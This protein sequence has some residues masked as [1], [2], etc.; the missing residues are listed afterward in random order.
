[1]RILFPT[2]ARFPS[3]TAPAVQVANMAQAFAEAG[4]DVTLIA[5]APDPKLAAIHPEGADGGARLFGFE[6]RYSSVVLA[7]RIHRGQSYVNAIRIARLVRARRPDLVFSR[8]LRS[9]LLPARAGVPTVFEAHT[10][11]SLEGPQERWLVRRLCATPA[12]RGIVAISAALAHDLQHALGVPEHLLHVAHDG[13]RL[14]PPDDPLPDDAP[15][16]RLRVGYTGSLFAGRGIEL[17]LEV[18]RRA[19]WIELHV[20]GGPPEAATALQASVS[21]G[22][23]GSVVIHGQRTP[24]EARRFQQQV[25][26]L[27]APFARRVSTNAG[28]DSSRWMSPMKLFEYLGSGRPVI[29][30][31]LPVLREVV[32]PEIDALMVPPEDPDALLRAL[33]RLLDDPAL[34]RQL[35]T[36]ARALMESDYTWGLRARRILDRFVPEAA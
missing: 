29:L 34:G 5:P 2:L 16:Q 7:Q 20:V 27:V 35:A 15:R 1:M 23:S 14:L 24:V 11:T 30:S 6:P 19:D 18:A 33:R 4:H 17:L 22:A 8:D 13:V 21:D 28:I 25:D 36:S 9:C 31:D 26:V 32:R 10:L 3:V 12:F